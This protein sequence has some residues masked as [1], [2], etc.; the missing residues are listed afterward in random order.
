[1]EARQQVYDHLASLGVAYTV[2]E[3]PPVYTVEEM[4]QLGLDKTGCIVKNLF[5]RD[6]KGKRHFLVMLRQDKKVNL[7]ELQETI[8]S[9]NLRFASEERL[10]KHLGLTKGAVSP[11][12]ILNDTE[13]CVELV[14]DNDLK[15]QK[16][17]GVHPNDNRATVWISFPDLERVMKNSENPIIHL[18]V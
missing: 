11:F 4:E 15:K 8:G 2:N 17:L 10:S 16:L 18:T 9:T 12:G 3:H 6:A 13:H 5:L 7:K 1:M 14:V